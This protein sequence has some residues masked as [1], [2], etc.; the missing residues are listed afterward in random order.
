MNTDI[1]TAKTLFLKAEY[2]QAAEI[3]HELA[4]SG[5]A[6]AAFD[7]G[8]CLWQGLGVP[9]DPTEAKS[10]DALSSRRGCCPQL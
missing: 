1:L 4:R 3:F 9:Y 2:K 7:Y 8:F 10:F 5:D 6:E